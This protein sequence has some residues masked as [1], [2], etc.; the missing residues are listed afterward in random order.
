MAST[1]F[2]FLTYLLQGFFEGHFYL[3]FLKL[4]TERL[5]RGPSFVYTDFIS[6]RSILPSSACWQTIPFCLLFSF[7]YT[8]TIHS[9]VFDFKKK[10]GLLERRIPGHFVVVRG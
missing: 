10:Q 3:L 6:V 9:P 8:S 4:Q 7:R 2:P 5:E 1:L